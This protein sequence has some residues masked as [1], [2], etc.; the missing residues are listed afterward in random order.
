LTRLEDLRRPLPRSGIW[1]RVERSALSL[2]LCGALLRATLAVPSLECRSG[3]SS[4][5]TKKCRFSFGRGS[6]PTKPTKLRIFAEG[7]Q[8]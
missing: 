4:T 5:F 7:P 8:K 3:I 2:A 6:I 1:S